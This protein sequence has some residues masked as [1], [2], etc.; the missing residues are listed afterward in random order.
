[1]PARAALIDSHCHLDCADFGGDLPAVLARARDA[2]LVTL[3]CIG[4][5]RDIASA[6]SAVAL[7]GR[8]ADIYATVGIHPHDVARM[9]EDD[10]SELGLLATAPRV[11]GIG[12]T[13]LDYHYN[14]SPQDVQQ[15][16]FRRFIQLAHA[17]NHALV[18]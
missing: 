18:C 11:V 12:E 1:M 13:G 14:H 8:E 3:V 16:A 15:V 10:W 7:A 17:S 6:R 5:G 9:G 2:G 4:S